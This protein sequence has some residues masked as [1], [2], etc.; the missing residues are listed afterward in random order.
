MSHVYPVAADKPDTLYPFYTITQ[1]KQPDSIT[2]RSHYPAP[3]NQADIGCC[4]AEAMSA[5][6]SYYHSGFVP[7]VLFQYYNERTISGNMNP[8]AGATLSETCQAAQR[9]GICQDALW[10][11]VETQVSV[12]PDPE[13]YT[14]AK[15][16]TLV[17]FYR[18]AAN[19]GQ[20]TITAIRNAV[21]IG[22]P[23]LVGVAVFPG[24][25]SQEAA[26]TGVVPLPLVNEQP[27]G[28]H[29][30]CVTGYDN[31]KQQFQFRNS[32]GTTWGDAGYGYFP[33]EYFLAGY[34]MSCWVITGAD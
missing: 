23:V 11:F 21:A 28:G 24:L 3:W 19:D 15:T 10:P 30:I 20:D 32:W 16:D 25:E 9:F 33:Y 7:S 8:Q 22:Q 14:K 27:L 18:I 29:A 5:A 1:K 26:S 2:W 34:L 13:C 17:S 6:M 31:V 4:T 12:K